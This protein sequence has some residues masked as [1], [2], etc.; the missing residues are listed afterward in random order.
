MNWLD[1]GLTPPGREGLGL[2]ESTGH[3][4]RIRA[5]EGNADRDGSSEGTAP[6]F[7]HPGNHSPPLGQ[8][9]FQ[10]S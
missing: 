10:L 5:D 8:G 2:G 6:D 9:A 1:E 3:C 4:G 7:I